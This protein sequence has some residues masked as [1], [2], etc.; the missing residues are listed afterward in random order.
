[1]LSSFVVGGVQEDSPSSHTVNLF[2]VLLGVGIATLVL[3]VVIVGS[4]VV[5]VWY[6]RRRAQARRRDL[7]SGT[8]A[9]D[10]EKVYLIRKN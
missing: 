9:C 8:V 3:C 2:A 6:K 7:S 5:A 10:T 1:M 4:V